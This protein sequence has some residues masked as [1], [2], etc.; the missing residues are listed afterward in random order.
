MF[1]ITFEDYTPPLRVDGLSWI[2]VRI[3]ESAS[4]TGPWNAIDT[5]DLFPVDP[6]PE[7]PMARAFTT[8]LATLVNGWYRVIFLDEIN[9]EALPTPPVQNIEDETAPYQPTISDIGALMRA[10]TLDAM[11]NEIGTF[12]DATRPTGEQVGNLI[13][14]AADD[15]MSGFDVDIPPGAYRYAKQA[16]IYRTAMLIEIG[17]WPEQ[18]N[19]GRSPYPQYEAMFDAFM[20]NLEKAIEREQGELI[21][22]EDALSPGMAVY[23]FPPTS[24]LV[25]WN[26]VW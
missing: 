12:N 25:G 10:R 22:G 1:S 7:D 5:I 18:I 13:I 26:T 6:N 14:Q 20:I 4:S 8:D 3:E 19:T 15:V 2:Q 16:I 17:Y 11:G 23:T 24:N 21:T 9:G